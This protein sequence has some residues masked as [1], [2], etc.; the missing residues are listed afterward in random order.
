MAYFLPC[1]TARPFDIRDW[2]S[3]AHVFPRKEPPNVSESVD[4][5]RSIDLPS[6]PEAPV[7]DDTETRSGVTSEERRYLSPNFPIAVPRDP[8]VWLPLLLSSPRPTKAK[9]PVHSACRRLDV[10]MTLGPARRRARVSGA[11]RFLSG[12]RHPARLGDVGQQSAWIIG[13]VCLARDTGVVLVMTRL[14]TAAM[15]LF[16]AEL[17]QAVAPGA[18]GIVLMDKAGWCTAGDLVVP[19]NLSLVFLPP[20]SPELNP[21]S[22][23]GMARRRRNACK[24]F[25]QQLR[26]DGE[27]DEHTAPPFPRAWTLRVIYTFSERVMVYNILLVYFFLTSG[28]TR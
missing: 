7:L 11:R 20:Y 27:S 21:I 23:A 12:R 4:D 15:N 6:R 8:S 13:A 17:G 22:P 14:D 28:Q 25:R 19:E 16:L 18:R 26:S 5:R 10:K 3:R 9:E 1:E 2:P 24:G